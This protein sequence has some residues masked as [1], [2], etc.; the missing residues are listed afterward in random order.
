MVDADPPCGSC[1]TVSEA[2][3]FG[4][5]GPNLDVL[6]PTQSQVVA[7]VTNGLG[8]MPAYSGKLSEEKIQQIARYIFEVTR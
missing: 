8:I 4:A 3:V 5:V 1:H 6:R 7:A 2:Q